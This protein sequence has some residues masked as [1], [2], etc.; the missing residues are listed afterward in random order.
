MGEEGWY[1]TCDE[2][3]VSAGSLSSRAAAPGIGVH[4]ASLEYAVDPGSST[5]IPC[6]LVNNGLQNDVFELVVEGVPSSWLSVPAQTLPVA[7]GQQ[8]EVTLAIQPPRSS[9]S[10]AGRHSVQIRVQS[11]VRPGQ[12]ASVACML[13]VGAFADFSAALDPEWAEAGQICRVTVENRGNI[14][15]DFALTWQSPDAQLRFDP[16]PSQS[17]RTRPGQTSAVEFQAWPRHRPI[18]GREKGHLFGIQVQSLTRDAQMLRGEIVGRA[19]A[20][21]WLL[22]AVLIFVLACICTLLVL[23]LTQ[24][25]L[26][27]GGGLGSLIPNATMEVGELILP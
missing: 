1:A 22:A 27:E 12:E 24:G 26:L 20:P 15:N 13:T 2:K 17:L 16:G 9:K 18:F 25:A 19:R 7:A 10:R 6:I 5:M 23:T 3:A 4:L 11:Q 14:R 21:T 8:R